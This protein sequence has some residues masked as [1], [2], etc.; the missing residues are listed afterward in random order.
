MNAIETILVD[1]SIRRDKSA[2]KSAGDA[3]GAC[4]LWGRDWECGGIGGGGL[5]DSWDRG[6]DRGDGKV[7]PNFVEEPLLLVEIKIHSL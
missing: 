3:R 5:C 2:G 1:D 6:S 7:I 4:G